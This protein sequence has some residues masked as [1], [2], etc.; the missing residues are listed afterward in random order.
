VASGLNSGEWFVLSQVEHHLEGVTSEVPPD[1]EVTA[2][3]I[4]PPAA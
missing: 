3:E 1:V 2:L 4:L